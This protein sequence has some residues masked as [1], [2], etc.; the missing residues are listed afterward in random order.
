MAEEGF[1]FSRDSKDYQQGLALMRKVLGDSDAR[2]VEKLL[3]HP[4][5][6]DYIGWMFSKTWGALYARTEL[7]I[8]ERSLVLMGTD[9]ASA[10][11]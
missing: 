11:R 1:P 7:S 9:M 6:G 3:D 8:R 5:F 2:Q 4:L 10:L